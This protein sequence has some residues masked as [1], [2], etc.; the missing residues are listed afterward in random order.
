[1]KNAEPSFEDLLHWAKHDPKRLE[2][3]QRERTGEIIN[4]AP[5]HIQ[6]RLRGLQFQI[7]SQ[8]ELHRSAMGRCIQISKM[9]QE[10]LDEMVQIINGKRNGISKT[11]KILTFPNSPQSKVS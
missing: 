8:R 2:R 7:D 9:M 10:S 6:R 3:Y 1:M 4:N 5:S 11:A